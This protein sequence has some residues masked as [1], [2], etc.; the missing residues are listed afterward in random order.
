M[1]FWKR[2]YRKMIP[3]KTLVNDALGVMTRKDKI[4]SHYPEGDDIALFFFDRRWRM[5]NQVLAFDEEA[6]RWYKE[7]RGR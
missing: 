4:V 7:R 1:F 6:Y 5:Y 3:N 2:R